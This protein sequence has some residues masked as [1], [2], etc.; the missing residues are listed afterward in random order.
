VRAISRTTLL[1]MFPTVFSAGT[2]LIRACLMSG[3]PGS[4]RDRGASE[5]SPMG[6]FCRTPVRIDVL[7]A[8]LEVVAPPA[9]G[10]GL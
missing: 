7:A 6:S 10:A 1:R 9:S 8:E 4:D 2:S 5:S 3:R